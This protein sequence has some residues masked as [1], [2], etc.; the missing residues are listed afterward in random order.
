MIY[1][2]IAHFSFIDTK[3]TPEKFCFVILP[4][5][6][7]TFDKLQK[8]RS[9]ANFTNVPIDD[10]HFYVKPSKHGSV[11]LSEFVG[12]KVKIT[13]K[14]APYQFKDKKSGNQLKGFNFKLENIERA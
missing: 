6:T 1:S 2:F 9:D 8:L 5:E 4:E 13:V 12:L 10:N 11:G 3:Y 14:M 7:S